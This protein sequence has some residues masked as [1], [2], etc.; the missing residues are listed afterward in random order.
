M[1]DHVDGHMDNDWAHDPYDEDEDEYYREDDGEEDEEKYR[2]VVGSWFIHQPLPVNCR[3]VLVTSGVLYGGPK[4][5]PTH[6]AFCTDCHTIRYGS[7]FVQR[8]RCALCGGRNTVSSRIR[9]SE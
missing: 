3:C 9:S 8:T 7:L 6:V 5:L 1:A 2:D 4:K